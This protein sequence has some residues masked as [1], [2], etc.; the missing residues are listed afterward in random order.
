MS[1]PE[2]SFALRAQDDD[3]SPMERDRVNLAAYEAKLA[4][5]LNPRALLYFY[6]WP[7]LSLSAGK[8]QI[9]NPL[10]HAELLALSERL[11]LPLVAR[12]SGGRLVLHGGD[13]CYSF[14]AAQNDKDFGGDLRSSFCKVNR[15]VFSA[16]RHISELQEFFEQGLIDTSQSFRGNIAEL[17]C[18]ASTVVGEGVIARSEATKQS[19]VHS[20]TAAQ[21]RDRRHVFA[22][23]IGAAQAMGTRAYIQQGSI[24]L[25]RIGIAE[26]EPELVLADLRAEEFDLAR[27]TAELNKLVTNIDGGQE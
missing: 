3:D 15:Y 17:K 8:L 27:I 12:P 16:L 21:K 4:E 20:S 22:K 18:F 24:Q 7:C 25:N 19:I 11:G 5:G 9:A 6:T 2:G 23:F 10:R 13:I 1:P 14:I 26:L